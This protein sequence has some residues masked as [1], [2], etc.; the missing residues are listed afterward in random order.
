MAFLIRKY[1]Q[2]FF[3]WHRLGLMYRLMSD[4][5]IFSSSSGCLQNLLVKQFSIGFDC[6]ISFSL[7]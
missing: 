7:I 6:H 2:R 4:L 1:F 3:T 5:Q